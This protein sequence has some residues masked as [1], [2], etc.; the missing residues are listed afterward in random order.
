LG[1]LRFAHALNG[2]PIPRQLQAWHDAGDMVVALANEQGWHAGFRIGDRLR[3]DALAMMASL[4]AQ[5]VK[6]AIFSGDTQ[7][8]V[9]KIAATLDITDARGGMGPE[10]KHRA[11]RH[12]QE[13]GACVAMVGDGVNDAP[14][15]AQAHVSIAMGG[16]ADLARSQADMVLLGNNLGAISEGV[17]LSR[18]TLRIVRQN[19]GWAFAYNVIFIP[20]AMCGWLTPW[21]AG[22]GMSVSSLLVVLNALRLQYSLPADASRKTAIQLGEMELES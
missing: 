12:L 8:V 14:V 3:G 9:Q 7:N 19:L 6:V 20:L 18:H 4:K 17:R 15:L 1:S 11:I 2:Q 5:G 21:L 22:A 13:H 16:G 10:D